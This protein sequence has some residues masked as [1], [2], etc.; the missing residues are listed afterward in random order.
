MRLRARLSLVA[1]LS[2]LG[3]AGCAYDMND[4]DDYG[5]GR[6]GDAPYGDYRYQGRDWAGGDT[7]FGGFSGPGADIL[8]PWLARTREGRDIVTLGF[9]DAAEGHLDAELA[10]R[11]NIWFRRYADTDRDLRLTDAEIRVALVQA[12]RAGGAGF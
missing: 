1:G 12:A 10:H 2:A 7:R 11:I 9:Q 5:Y 6:A 3:A 4:Y 8:D